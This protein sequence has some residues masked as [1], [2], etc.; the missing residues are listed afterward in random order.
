MNTTPLE[1]DVLENKFYARGIGPVLELDLS[2]ERGT[3]L[4]NRV[5]HR[6]P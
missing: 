1:P 5:T 4:L 3:A 2:P 6:A